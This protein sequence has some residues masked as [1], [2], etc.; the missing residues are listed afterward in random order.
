[1]HEASDQGRLQCA[2]I[3]WAPLHSCL[4]LTGYFSPPGRPQNAP[5]KKWKFSE[6]I[7]K[8]WTRRGLVAVEGGGWRYMAGP[9]WH[10]HTHKHTVNTV[11]PVSWPSSSQGAERQHTFLAW[12]WKCGTRSLQL[13]I[14]PLVHSAHRDWGPHNCPKTLSVLL[15][16]HTRT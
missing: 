2:Y 1:M 14:R 8:H 10:T 12:N 3:I 15:W 4:G 6:W 13:L 16:W 5:G 7:V 11:L 9:D